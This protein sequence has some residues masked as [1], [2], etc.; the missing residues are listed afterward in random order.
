MNL[1]GSIAKLQSSGAR[2]Y[3]E[4]AQYFKENNLIRDIWLEMAHDEEQQADS[5]KSLPP[6]FWN[7]LREREE[8]LSQALGTHSLPAGC[9][10]V[11]ERNLHRCFMKT[12]EFE[13]PIIL[14]VYAPLIR[15]LRTEWTDRALDF[16]I[17]VKA[18]VARLLRV[19]G[20]FSGD[21]I[22]IQRT[23][24]LLQSFEKE[25]QTPESL[26]VPANPTQRKAATRKHAAGVHKSPSRKA[27]AKRSLPLSKRPKAIA[28]RSKSLVK[29]IGL[30]R[31]R[32]SR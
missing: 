32:A 18:H 14:K 8:E 13:E 10:P 23:D 31:R 30:R 15:Q 12:L 2:M 24:A 11:E 3:V 22:L 19:V 6:L 28:Q 29:K 16:Y 26:A 25:V 27:Q 5:L 7:K 1:R 20:S 21:P 9:A 4:V 17:M